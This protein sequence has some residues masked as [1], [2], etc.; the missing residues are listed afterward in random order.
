MVDDDISS[1][2]IPI[3][4]PQRW[5]N[6]TQITSD[7]DN[8]KKTLLSIISSL[9]KLDISTNNNEQITIS[10][11]S[12]NI[13]HNNQIDDKI[14]VFSDLEDTTTIIEQ[15]SNDPSNEPSSMIIKLPNV[16]KGKTESHIWKLHETIKFCN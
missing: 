11:D 4:D 6:H 9:N 12:F 8:Y 14:N 1:K 16:K 15:N 2:I 5:L 7:E 13:N 3:I 10:G